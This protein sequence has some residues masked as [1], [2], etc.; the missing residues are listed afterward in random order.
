M[1]LADNTILVTGGGSG[2]GLSLAKAFALKNNTVVVCGRDPFSFRWGRATAS[3][4]NIKDNRL[5][6]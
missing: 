4:W 6:S 3:G 5:F 1:K 2:I